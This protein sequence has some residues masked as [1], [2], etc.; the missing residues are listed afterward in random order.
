M[1]VH[2]GKCLEKCPQEL[3]GFTACH[4]RDGAA[5]CAYF[6]WLEKEVPKGTVTEISAAE[7]LLEF[8]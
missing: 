8:R 2:V 5:L 7:K 4:V 3:E 6:A 1:Y